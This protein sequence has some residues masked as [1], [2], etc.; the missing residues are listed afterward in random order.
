VE[1]PQSVYQFRWF[2][3]IGSG[4]WTQVQDFGQG[5][6]ATYTLTSPAAGSYQV[7]VH[8]R[9]A[10]SG[11]VQF[12][13][14]PFTHVVTGG[15]PTAATGATIAANPVSGSPAGTNVVF[16][17][18]GLGSTTGGVESPQSAYQFRWFQRVGNGA[19]TQVQDF[20]QGGGATYTLT[21]PAA[22]TYQVAVHVRAAT[23]GPAQFFGPGVTHVVNGATPTRATGATI[24]ANPGSGSSA[25]TDV[26]FSAVGLGSTTGGLES[27][28]SVYQF[29]WFLK[30]GA[31]P[32]TQVQDFGQGGGAT[33]TLESP[34]A[35]SYQVAVHVRAATS[36]PVQ[37]FGPG[38]PHVV[39]P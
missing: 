14:P 39:V 23:S 27:P 20:G 17:A 15:T 34:A 35:G 31:G 10:T 5:G 2:Q 21:A 36:G 28:Q 30:V 1:S 12:F 4:A 22:G 19:W 13:G 29:R 37:Y 6:G 11:P 25:G 7:A 26:V 3:R 9:A 33:Y 24:T 38:V 16:S 18:T 8:V 32:W